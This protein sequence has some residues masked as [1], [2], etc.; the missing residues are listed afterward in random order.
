MPMRCVVTAIAPMTIRIAVT[1]GTSLMKLSLV[2]RIK[3]N[4]SR[5]PRVK[6]TRRKSAVPS[7]L[8]AR[9][10]AFTLP[11]NARLEVTA[12]MVHPTVSSMIAEATSVMPMLRRMKPISRTTMATIFTDAIESAVP[13]N[14]E[15]I[16]R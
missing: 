12:M 16:S 11:C 5:R 15:V 8:C 3:A 2:Q 10:A 9:L 1:T 13:R 6:L 14:K 4:T 7:T